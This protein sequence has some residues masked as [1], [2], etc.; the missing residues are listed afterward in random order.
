M[1]YEKAL[2]SLHVK[3]NVYFAILPCHRSFLAF[4][5]FAIPL[6]LAWPMSALVPAI[7]PPTLTPL[8]NISLTNS[9]PA[10]NT[11]NKLAIA[12]WLILVPMSSQLPSSRTSQKKFIVSTS[13]IAMTSMNRLLGATPSRR[14]RI[15]RLAL[16]TSKGINIFSMRSAPC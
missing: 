4:S 13:E 14:V 9:S 1:N 15:P 10:T 7:S 16:M 3:T 2:F 11:H 8:M 5:C 6:P 12:K